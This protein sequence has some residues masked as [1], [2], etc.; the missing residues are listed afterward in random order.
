VLY[1]TVNGVEIYH[2]VRGEG[3]A[4][5]GIHGTPSTAAMWESAAQRLAGVGR[6]ITYDRRGFGRSGRPDPFDAVDLT[7]H[8]DDAIALLDALAATPAV[9]LGR[10]TGGLVALELA[11][12]APNRVRALVLLEPALLSADPRAQAKADEVRRAALRLGAHD[13]AAASEAVLR[14]F[15][16]DAFWVALPPEVRNLVSAAGE[17]VLAEIR[18]IGLDLSAHPLTL[19]GDELAAVRPPTLLVSGADSAETFRRV[20]DH[21]ARHLPDARTLTVPGGHV[22]DPAGPGVLDFIRQ[23]IVGG[24]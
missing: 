14:G 15:L 12:R 8:V 6:C 20:N 7:D 13:P 22:I 9:V 16:G 17:A 18:G 11:R 3:H 2:E 24:S 19:T 10:S 23:V 1:V 5:L 4:L 21:L